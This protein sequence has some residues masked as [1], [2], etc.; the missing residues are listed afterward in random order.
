MSQFKNQIFKTLKA[1]RAYFE[2]LEK[3][4]ELYENKFGQ[5]PS[6]ADDDFW[7]DT[8]HGKQSATPA[9]IIKMSQF[10]NMRSN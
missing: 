5:N 1:K 9:R 3:A 10:N 4:E 6:E 2:E 8:M 7:I